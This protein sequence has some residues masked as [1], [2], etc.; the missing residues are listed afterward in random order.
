MRQ[1][2]RLDSWFARTL[3]WTQMPRRPSQ[4][5]RQANDRSHVYSLN[6]PSVCETNPGLV[7]QF[8][9]QQDPRPS[10]SGRARYAG[11]TAS[12][13]KSWCGRDRR[14]SLDGDGY[15]LL[16][17]KGAPVFRKISAAGLD[18]RLQPRWREPTVVSGRTIDHPH[19]RFATG[20]TGRWHKVDEAKA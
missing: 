12:R 13:R 4:E 2:P 5:R 19:I 18:S 11:A 7:S 17:T 3:G 9:C 20:Q 16:K 6:T 15:L 8:K 14:S 1:R 10:P